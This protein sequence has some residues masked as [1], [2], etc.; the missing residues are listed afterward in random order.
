MSHF[1]VAVITSPNEVLED[2]LQPFHEYECTGIEDKYVV[3]VES[4]ESLEDMEKEHKSDLSE[5]PDDTLEDFGQYVKDYYG[6]ELRSGVWGRMTNPNAQWDWWTIGGRWSGMLM[7]KSGR[8]VDQGVLSS[9]D[10]A[11]VIRNARHKAQNDFDEAAIII[12]GRTWKSWNDTRKSM[13]SI[14]EARDFYHKQEVVCD[15]CKINDHPFFDVDQFL[16]DRDSYIDTKGNS[17][18][19][20]FAVVKD[21]V[22]YQ[23]GDMGWWGCVSD[24]KD[25]D[26]WNKEYLNL[27]KSTPDD[28]T[29]TIVDCHI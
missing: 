18:I 27:L 3:F 22:W 11:T 25:Q 15:L 16:S 2:V 28:H 23:K 24:E 7:D 21:G 29:L 12:N 13:G 20:T 14:D 6:Y 26:K 10:F 4:N 5:Y 1:T 8:K 9:L 19:S 17:S